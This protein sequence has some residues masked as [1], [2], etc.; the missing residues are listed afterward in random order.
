VTISTAQAL[1]MIGIG[2]TVATA[3]FWSSFYIGKIMSRLDRIDDSIKD[4]EARLDRLA[5]RP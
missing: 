1:A 5:L 2:S 3:I 4:H